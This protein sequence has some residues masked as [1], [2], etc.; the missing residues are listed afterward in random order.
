MGRENQDEAFPDMGRYKLL[1]R[2]GAQVGKQKTPKLAWANHCPAVAD[3]R[4]VCDMPPE[5]LWLLVLFDVPAIQQESNS[6]AG[7]G[8]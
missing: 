5:S 8:W 4:L 6:Y 1:P 3:H 7:G 2:E